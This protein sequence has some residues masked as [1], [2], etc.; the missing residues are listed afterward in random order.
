MR[1]D[2]F[3]MYFYLY[4]KHMAVFMN[5]WYD[6]IMCPCTILLTRELLQRLLEDPLYIGKRSPRV[7]GPMYDEFIDEFVE[8][9]VKR[10]LFWYPTHQ[11]WVL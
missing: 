8:A 3:M 9:V 7:T 10:Y 5:C 11:N 2:R 6:M 1:I 4:N